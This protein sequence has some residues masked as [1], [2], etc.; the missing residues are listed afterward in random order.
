MTNVSFDVFIL[1][2]YTIRIE[3]YIILLLMQSLIRFLKRNG[4]EP[5]LLYANTQI[6]RIRQRIGMHMPVDITAESALA[7]F[8][9]RNMRHND[10]VHDLI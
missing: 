4:L 2:L 6:P 3:L 7:R 9:N 8:M 10:I 1:V 5:S